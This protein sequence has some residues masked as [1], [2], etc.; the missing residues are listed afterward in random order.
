MESKDY[1]QLD[2][3]LRRKSYHKL[4]ADELEFVTEQIGGE[5]PYNELKEM[6]MTAMQSQSIPVGVAVKQDLVHRFK[7]KHQRAPFFWLRYQMPAY[8]NVLL[9]VIAVAAAWYLKPVEQVIIDR[10]VTVQL[11]GRTDTLMI[12]S[13]ADTIFIEKR[14][15]VEVP[16]YITKTAEPIKEVSPKMI[17]GNSMSDQ[18]GLRDLLVSGK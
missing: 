13:P 18:Q 15:R 8:V 6:V 1:N 7:G 12:S 2:E 4:T 5:K 3:L 17:Q 11:P 10:P 14:I 9:I 16:V